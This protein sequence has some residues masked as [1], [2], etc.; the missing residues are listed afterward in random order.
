MLLRCCS[1][2]VGVDCCYVVVAVVGLIVLFDIGVLLIRWCCFIDIA[3]LFLLLL[4]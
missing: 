1:V 4:L 3:M 2:V